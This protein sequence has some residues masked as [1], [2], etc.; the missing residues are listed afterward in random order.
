[1]FDSL[2]AYASINGI[3]SLAQIVK[4]GP[5]SVSGSATN[6]IVFESEVSAPQFNG[7]LF[8]VSVRTTCP[9]AIS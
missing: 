6:V 9:F 5:A 4:S 7:A 2:I 8:P 3:C 1:M